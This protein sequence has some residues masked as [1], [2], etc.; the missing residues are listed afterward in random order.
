MISLQSW[1]WPKR[2][3][4]VPRAWAAG[5]LAA[6]GAVLF[7]VSAVLLKT[8]TIGWDESLFRLLN[9]VPAAAASVLTPLSHLFLPTGIVIVI[10]L[11]IG[12]VLIRDRSI[13]PVVTGVAAAVAAWLLAH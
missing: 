9:D 3:A 11:I 12:Y 13:L 2:P 1:W 7:G 6:L 8:G 4:R 10:V 5:L